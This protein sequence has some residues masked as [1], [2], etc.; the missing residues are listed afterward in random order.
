MPRSCPVAAKTAA[1]ALAGVKA[2]DCIPEATAPCV[3]A[4]ESASRSSAVVCSTRRELLV[5]E[6]RLGD[7]RLAVARVEVLVRRLLVAAHVRLE[8]RA[9]GLAP[10][11]AASRS[12]CSARRRCG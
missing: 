5:G 12:P 9:L 6:E 2:T 11:R 4:Q 8:D 7:H 1:I 10:A 3:P